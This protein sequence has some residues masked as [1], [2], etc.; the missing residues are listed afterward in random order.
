MSSRVED[1]SRAKCWLA[2]L[3]LPFF[4][5]VPALAQSE[6]VD[7]EAAVSVRISGAP[8]I[9]GERALRPSELSSDAVVLHEGATVSFTVSR[10]G[11]LIG[12]PTKAVREQFGDEVSAASFSDK[13]IVIIGAA[14]VIAGAPLA[15]LRVTS[16]YGARRHPIDGV[17][18][19]HAGIDYG[20]AY[21]TPIMAT[22]DGTVTLA[23]RAGGYGLLVKLD[24][25]S[26]LETRYAHMSRIAVSVGDRVTNGQ[27][28]GYVGATGRTTGSH[29]HYE[30]RVNGRA[31]DPLSR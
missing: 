8:L 30:T 13:P 17:T 4:S 22:G 28:I 25:G 26:G 14:P 27:V 9:G 21:G 10:G 2:A 16:R 3:F 5:A 6:M 7:D 18:R 31:V 24:H 15:N 20:A 11:D 29:L 19:Q 23:G 12:A 1:H